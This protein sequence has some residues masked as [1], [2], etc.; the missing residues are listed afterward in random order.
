[1]TWG[2]PPP[3]LILSAAVIGVKGLSKDSKR[4]PI[5]GGGS[6][7]SVPR[8]VVKDKR[9]I[10]KLVRGSFLVSGDQS[11]ARLIGGRTYQV[12]E[13]VEVDLPNRPIDGIRCIILELWE[14]KESVPYAKLK[15]LMRK[16]VTDNMFEML[17]TVGI[18]VQDIKLMDGVQELFEV[19][20]DATAIIDSG[21]TRTIV[22][23]D[24]YLV[25]GSV[26]ELK[27]PVLFKGFD[28]HGKAQTANFAGMIAIQS[29]TSQT[30]HL[31][32]DAY[33]LPGARRPLISMSQLDEGG[34]YVDMGGVA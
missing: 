32:L 19:D 7:G 23:N 34:N 26:Y 2:H 20:M 17:T 8:A 4:S 1:V 3:E 29:N 28:K 30:G 10:G 33:I 31:L 9:P 14:T 12:G 24:S 25:K 11:S 21:A 22:P 16:D 6:S 5:K 15:P 27:K 18:R 13:G